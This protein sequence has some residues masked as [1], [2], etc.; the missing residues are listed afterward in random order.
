[1]GRRGTRRCRAVAPIAVVAFQGALGLLAS[2]STASFTAVTSNA[3][4]SLSSSVLLAPDPLSC[5]WTGSNSLSLAW[6]NTTSWAA[7]YDYERSNTSGSGFGALGSTSGATS[8]TGTDANPAP[9]TVRYYRVH[10]KYATNWVSP[11][12]SEA[13]SDTCDGTILSLFASGTASNAL[14]VA[15]DAAGNV[16][17]TD[18]TNNRVLKTT[19]GG[20]TTVYAGTGVAGYS[21]DGGAATS[22]KLNSPRGMSVDASGNLYIADTSNNAI[23]KVTAAGIISTVAGT[24]VAGYTGDSA[25]ATSAQI[26]APS[27]VNVDSTGALYIGDT[28]NHV[29]RKV[30]A[31]G[32]I[33]TFAGTGTAGYTGDGGSPTAA[34]LSSPFAAVSDGSGTV[35]ITDTNNNVIR[36]VSGGVITTVAGGGAQPACSYTGAATSVQLSG[37]RRLAWDPTNSR[38]FIADLGNDCVRA[39]SGSTITLTAGTGTTSYTGDHG[40]AIAATFAAPAAL[41]YSTAGDLYIADRDNGTIRKILQP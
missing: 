27:S 5:A 34:R 39:F 1:M 24:G 30:T 2:S 3:G 11:A 26:N 9:P 6:T 38:L 18:N 35:F 14:G 4:D 23:R 19:P 21:G 10:S 15:V 17:S 22:A 29:I 36:K 20:T 40:P 37:P 41:A 7:G 8:V 12:S 13:A 16:Y 33:S 32:I 28:N 31:G 25:A